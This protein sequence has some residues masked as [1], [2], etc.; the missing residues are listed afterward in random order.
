[1]EHTQSS[2]MTDDS[3]HTYDMPLDLSMKK[4]KDDVTLQVAFMEQL[5]L[6]LTRNLPLS[7][8]QSSLQLSVDIE[9]GDCHTTISKSDYDQLS[10]D[11]KQA[12]RQ[13]LRSIFGRDTLASSCLTGKPSNGGYIFIQL[14]F[15]FVF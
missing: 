12:L 14:F 1:M 6:S 10:A 8:S 5:E 11:Y 3:I 4:I 9:L 15:L 2:L 13:L 7:E